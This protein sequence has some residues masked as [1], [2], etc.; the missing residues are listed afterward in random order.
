MGIWNAVMTYGKARMVGRLLR[1][2]VGGKLST[3]LLVA[4]M[5]KKA[6]DHF[7]AGRRE[8]VRS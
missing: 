3:A 7:R 8:R 2:G 1:R 5:G 4:Y 6:Y